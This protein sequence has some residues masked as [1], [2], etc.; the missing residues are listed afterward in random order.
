MKALVEE[1]LETNI[2]YRRSALLTKES[3]CEVLT[4]KYAELDCE[5]SVL[6]KVIVSALY[7]N[8]SNV[9]TKL[10]SHINTTALLTTLVKVHRHNSVRMTSPATES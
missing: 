8:I 10:E 9:K 2:E 4:P 3:D 5:L 6:H 7:A 1:G